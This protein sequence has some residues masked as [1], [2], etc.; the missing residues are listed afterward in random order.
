M[1]MGWPGVRN[2]GTSVAEVTDGEVNGVGAAVVDGSGVG[3]VAGDDGEG[4]DDDGGALP[5]GAGSVE[6]V[7]LEEGDACSLDVGGEADDTDRVDCWW[8]TTMPNRIVTVAIT[9]QPIGMRKPIRRRS[10]AI[11]VTFPGAHPRRDRRKS[12]AAGQR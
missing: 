4:A 11:V 2:A 3:V 8:S 9:A 7:T 6:G 10:F 1:V 12:K 5:G